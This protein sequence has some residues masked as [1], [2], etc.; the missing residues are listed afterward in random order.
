MLSLFG[1]STTYQ[2]AEQE[3]PVAIREAPPGNAAPNT[4]GGTVATPIA[5]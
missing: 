4:G 5:G 3:L 1:D 2:T